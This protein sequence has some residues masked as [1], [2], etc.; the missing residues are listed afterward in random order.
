M[1][2]LALLFSFLREGRHGGRT[3]PGRVGRG[4][5]DAAAVQGV[6]GRRVGHDLPHH[7][8]PLLAKPGDAQFRHFT[9][10]ALLSDEA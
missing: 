4:G 10:F 6:Q 1:L 9:V 2:D 8:H 3:H 7:R 5:T